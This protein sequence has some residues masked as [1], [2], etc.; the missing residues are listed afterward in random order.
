MFICYDSQ[1][2]GSCDPRSGIVRAVAIRTMAKAS[3]YQ[4][5]VCY[6]YQQQQYLVFVI[7]YVLPWP[8]RLLN[9]NTMLTSNATILYVHNNTIHD[10]CNNINSNDSNSTMAKAPL[11]LLVFVLLLVVVVLLLLLQLIIITGVSLCSSSS[12]SMFIIISSS[13]SI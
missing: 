8:R 5:Y 3:I 7:Y 11:Y 2:D 13:S 10:T 6:Y 1:T 4:L 12:S 9:V